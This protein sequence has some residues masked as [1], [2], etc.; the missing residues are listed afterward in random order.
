[1]TQNVKQMNMGKVAVLMGGRAAEKLVFELL[2]TGAAD[3]LAKATDMARDMVTRYGM[4]EG[5]GY[6][7]FEPKRQQML[8]LPA[9]VLPQGSPVSEHT[10]KCIDDAIRGI[11]M[12]GF[13]QAR[14]IL[15]ANRAVLERGAVRRDRLVIFLALVMDDAD[16]V[17]RL[18]VLRVELDR[19]AQ[20]DRRVAELAAL[21]QHFAE[22][23][24]EA[25]GLGLQLDRP[26]QRGN[27]LLAVAERVE[28]DAED[29]VRVRKTRPGGDD[30]AAHALRLLVLALGE[31][32]ARHLDCARR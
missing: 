19:L 32:L 2:S 15:Q 1:M 22:V 7:A 31:Q 5:L 21:A 28:R 25:G 11:V 10:R 3:D 17:E 30:L 6:V 16:V 27:R 13:A 18:R 23:G 4:D 26:L 9:G 24:V 29:V 8:E 20:R 12:A 14:A